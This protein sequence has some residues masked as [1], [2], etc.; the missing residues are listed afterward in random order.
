MKH[1]H[2]TYD[3]K[4]GGS[5]DEWEEAL[6][7]FGLI[8]TQDPIMEGSDQYG[9]FITQKEPTEDQL[10]M[11]MVEHYGQDFIDEMEQEELDAAEEPE[12][13]PTCGKTQDKC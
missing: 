9:F 2:V 11:M 5:E 4:Q 3:W 13:C 12:P 1:S 10:R 6:K 8:L 7:D